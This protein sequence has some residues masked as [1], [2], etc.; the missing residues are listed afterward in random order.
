MQ[1]QFRPSNKPNEEWVVVIRLLNLKQNLKKGEV[2]QMNLFKPIIPDRGEWEQDGPGSLKN[3]VNTTKDIIKILK[4]ANKAHFDIRVVLR[5]PDGEEVW[6]PSD[7]NLEIVDVDES[8]GTLLVRWSF[9]AKKRE[10]RK[11]RTDYDRL[12][13]G[14]VVAAWKYVPFLKEANRLSIIAN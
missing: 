10:S 6:K 13:C 4:I 9:D 1:M 8:A 5:T 14:G 7:A 2:K 11:K 12:I 3:E